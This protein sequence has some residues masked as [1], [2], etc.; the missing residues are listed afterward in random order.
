[1][2]M[3]KLALMAACAAA[4]AGC[5]VDPQAAAERRDNLMERVFPNPADRQGLFLAFP[6][7]SGGRVPLMEIIYFVED[8]S[9]AEVLARM[10]RFCAGQSASWTNGATIDRELGPQDL[11]LANGQVRPG[12]AFFLRCV[13][14]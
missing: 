4:V 11:T 1:M 2:R 13:G 5:S 14:S 8:V 9:E 12:R 6:L 3:I 7:E 10:G